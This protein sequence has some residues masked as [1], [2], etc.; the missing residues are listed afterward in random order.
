MYVLTTNDKTVKLWKISDKN[1][2]KIIKPSGKE[3]GMPKL[4]TVESGLIPSI[5]KIFPNLHNYH[6]NSLSLAQNEEFVLTSDDL[7]VIF[8]R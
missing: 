8:V 5:R 3:L 4:Q 2:K 7:K 1:I 6:I